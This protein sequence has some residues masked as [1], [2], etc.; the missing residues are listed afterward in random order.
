MKG[1]FAAFAEKPLATMVLC[2]LSA[3]LA[4]FLL[5]LAVD[6]VRQLLFRALRVERACK[7]LCKKLER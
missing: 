4:I 5:A 7:A 1:R 6:A 2:I 3:A